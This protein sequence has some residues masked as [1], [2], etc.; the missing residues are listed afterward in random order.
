MGVRGGFSPENGLTPRTAYYPYYPLLPLLPPTYRVVQRYVTTAY[1]PYYP[2][3]CIL[4]LLPPTYSVHG[5]HMDDM[6]CYDLWE[7]S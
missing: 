6:I 1:Y 2:Y 7:T 5:S 4:P 3:Y